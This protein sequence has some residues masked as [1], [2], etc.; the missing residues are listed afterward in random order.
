M[1]VGGIA[2]PGLAVC[3]QVLGMVVDV[4]TRCSVQH[5]SEAGVEVVVQPAVGPRQSFGLR[6]FEASTSFREFSPGLRPI[7]QTRAVLLVQR[8]RPFE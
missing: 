7:L 4:R 6:L 8:S 3:P 2:V 1:L 5:W